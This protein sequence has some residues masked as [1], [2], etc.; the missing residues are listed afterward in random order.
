MEKV[1]IFYG[2]YEYIHNAIWYI[3][4]IIGN[5]TAIW[6]YFPPFLVHF[7]KKNLA[8][9]SCSRSPCRRHFW[10]PGLMGNANY[11]FADF[12]LTKNGTN[13]EKPLG[14]RKKWKSKQEPG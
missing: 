14:T 3:L 13:G 10:E 2:H 6:L 4:K 5:L 8:T 11:F 9:L 12:Q 1:G 7:V